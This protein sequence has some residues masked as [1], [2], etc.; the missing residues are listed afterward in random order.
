MKKILIA[1]ATTSFCSAALHAQVTSITLSNFGSSVD[2]SS[3]LTWNAGTNTVSGTENSGEGL[4]PTS[5]T[6]ADLTTLQNYSPTNLRL[7]LTGLVTTAPSAGGA[8]TITLEGN[9]GATIS[10]P[11]N[12]NLFSSSSSTVSLALASTPGGF[13]YNNIVG[14]TWDTGNSG[15]A[16]NATWTGL[17]VTAVP[18]PSTYALMALS[19]LVL[20]F[21]ARRRKAQV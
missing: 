12:W 6:S 20:F 2:A 10:T 16:I 9:G 1:L 15:Q 18:E 13:S 11:F 4:A 5:F 7:N 8:F 19:G 14:W 3:G 17:T 21:I